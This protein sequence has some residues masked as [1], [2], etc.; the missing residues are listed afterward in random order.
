LILD[1][2]SINGS[3]EG[4]LWVLTDKCVRFQ[5]QPT[6]APGLNLIEPR[7]KTFCSVALKEHR[8]KGTEDLVRAIAGSNAHRKEYRHPYQWRK[9]YP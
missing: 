3:Q 8:F 1:K 9:Q 6:Y 7:W 2:L 4:Q 5:F